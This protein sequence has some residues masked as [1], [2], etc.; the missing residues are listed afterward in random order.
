MSGEVHL[1]N[2]KISNFAPGKSE[3]KVIKDIASSN[4]VDTVSEDRLR[5]FP[6]TSKINEAFTHFSSLKTEIG[7][8]SQAGTRERNCSSGYAFRPRG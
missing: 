1:E 5:H 7:A 4:V 2:F 3:V 6:I 8:Y